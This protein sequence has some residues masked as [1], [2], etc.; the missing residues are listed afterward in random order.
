MKPMTI[1]MLKILEEFLRKGGS[2]IKVFIA[3]SWNGFLVG[4]KKKKS[5]AKL[6]ES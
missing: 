5:L 3:F 6:L 1:T 2:F 4:L